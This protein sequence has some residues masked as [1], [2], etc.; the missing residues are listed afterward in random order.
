MSKYI[1]LAL[2]CVKRVSIVYRNKYV[3]IRNKFNI[4]FLNR[5][6][7]FKFPYNGENKKHAIVDFMRDPSAHM[8]Q[9]K[10]TVDE[11]WSEDTDV[12]HLTGILI[13]QKNSKSHLIFVVRT[14][15]NMFGVLINFVANVLVTTL[16]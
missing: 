3:C 1:N 14:F 12:V 2:L 10:E 9:K 16:I 15:D 6:G 7:L 5:N 13:F 4:Y 11:G 8:H